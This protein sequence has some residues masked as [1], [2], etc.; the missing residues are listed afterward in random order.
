[1]DLVIA[2]GMGIAAEVA[3]GGKAFSGGIEG[4]QAAG[5]GADPEQAAAVEMEGE[6]FI[7]AGSGFAGV[8]EKA[9]DP[10]AVAADAVEAVLGAH[11]E[12]AAA[13]QEHGVDIVAAEQQ[14]GTRVCA[15]ALK[16]AA[17][18]VEAVE[19]AVF[20][21]DPE[22]A[23]LVLGQAADEVG[24]EAAGIGGI[25]LVDDKVV[26][27]VAVE[28]LVGAAPDEALAVLE[29]AVHLA[30]G[31]SLIDGEVAELQLA[32]LAVAGLGPGPLHAGGGEGEEE[33]ENEAWRFQV[34]PSSI[35][36]RGAAWQGLVA[37]AGGSAA[38]FYV[39]AAF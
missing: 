7:G 8:G 11:P 23:L 4:E 3:I 31:K 24:G 10:A 15:E 19:A 20:S 30:V 22:V 17:V 27:V 32:L 2:E 12:A 29:K 35:G 1:M 37:M 36:L 9:G 28:P 25:L 39:F 33:D 5:V 6:Y 18:P 16:G 14:P 13:V 34:G 38:Q 26:A 21:A